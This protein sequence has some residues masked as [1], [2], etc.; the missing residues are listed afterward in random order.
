MR[1]D[2]VIRAQAVLIAIGI[3]WEGHRRVLAVELANR[4][5]HRA[6]RSGHDSK[7]QNWPNAALHDLVTHLRAVR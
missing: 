3:N 5:S 7:S 6:N 1:E 2:G 4:E